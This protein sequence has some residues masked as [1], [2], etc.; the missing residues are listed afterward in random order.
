MDDLDTPS[1]S[2]ATEDY[3]AIE[4]DNYPEPI[5][6]LSPEALAVSRKHRDRILD[7]LEQEEEREEHKSLQESQ[8]EM[9]QKREAAR[10]EMDKRMLT[11]G[12]DLEKRKQAKELEKKMAKSLVSGL[13]ESETL[14]PKTPAAHPDGKAKKVVTFA[15]P[16]SAGSEVFPNPKQQNE[17]NWGDVVPAM[18]PTWKRRVASS[19]TQPMKMDVVE[20]TSLQSYNSVS[21]PPSLEFLKDTEP[22]KDSDDESDL[23]L[24]DPTVLESENEDVVLFAQ[25]HRELALEYHRQREA[26]VSNAG[27]LNLENDEL[28]SGAG[29]DATSWDKE[30]RSYLGIDDK[31]SFS[32]LSQG[33]PS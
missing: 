27:T 25:R 24:S 33:S 9:K 3:D 18:L 1:L 20:R 13:G 30:V 22:A 21:T 17:I 4:E 14:N 32:L 12:L 31:H 5:S 2:A 8:V 28:L 10:V 7:L 11:Q 15:D 26:L 29:H 16:P 19:Q 23:G 6:K